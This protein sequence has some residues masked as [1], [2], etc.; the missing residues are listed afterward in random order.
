MKK[1]NTVEEMNKLILQAQPNEEDFENSSNLIREYFTNP[2]FKPEDESLKPLFDT[3]STALPFIDEDV[4]M[5][6][7]V[8]S[9]TLLSAF[10]R[11]SNDKYSTELGAR[12][13]YEISNALDSVAKDGH[14]YVYTD[15]YF[16]DKHH[17][18]L[19]NNV[20][21]NNVAE[22]TEIDNELED[23]LENIDQN[24]VV[25]PAK[26]ASDISIISDDVYD[27]KN[28]TAFILH[29]I[30]SQEYYSDKELDI[31]IKM[32]I[33]SHEISKETDIYAPFPQLTEKHIEDSSKI[34]DMVKSN[35][36]NE[37]L[38][39]SDDYKDG[40]SDKILESMSFM[41]FSE[42]DISNNELNK[43]IARVYADSQAGLPIDEDNLPLRIISDFAMQKQGG[44]YLDP[45]ASKD[46]YSDKLANIF[47][48]PD[49]KIQIEDINNQ[50]LG[51]FDKLSKSASVSIRADIIS[52]NNLE[53]EYLQNFH[54][55]LKHNKIQLTP[56]GIDNLLKTDEQ[57]LASEEILKNQSSSKDFSADPL[58]NDFIEKQNIKESNPS[59]DLK[60]KQ[61]NHVESDFSIA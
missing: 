20:V 52:G 7:L 12:S 8:M 45:S 30:S 17:D 5:S 27:E 24:S 49:N 28:P 40:I 44:I 43:S 50:S 1:Y 21:E 14:H 41:N 39:L 48:N 61:Q 35:D 13:Y 46:L 32:S 26:Y 55:I 11:E 2:D 53:P 60:P 59:K 33:K 6:A 10:N 36:K 54:D 25:E 18:T 16:K 19:E 37:I 47:K 15:I 9:A 4:D 38:S 3:L 23:S 58:V 42:A 31:F 51:N 56:K 29:N 34:I 57:K 22:N